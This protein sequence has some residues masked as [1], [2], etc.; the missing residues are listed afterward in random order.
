[1]VSTVI[2][3][4]GSLGL[5]MREHL[6]KLIKAQGVW[7]ESASS[8]LIMEVE[9]VRVVVCGEGCIRG[10]ICLARSGR[11]ILSSICQEVKKLIYFLTGF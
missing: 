2:L 5:I 1:M 7:F 10:D 8:P 11:S 3:G 4:D 9:A 6:R